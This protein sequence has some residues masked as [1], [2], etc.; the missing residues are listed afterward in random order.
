[1]AIADR[2]EPVSE[3]YFALATAAIGGDVYNQVNYAN[4]FTVIA[5]QNHQLDMASMRHSVE[6]RSPLLDFG[7]ME[8]LMSVPDR[9]KNEHGPK[10]LMRSLVSGLLPEYIVRARKSGPTMPLDDW[11]RDQSVGGTAQRFVVK[12]KDLIADCCSARLASAVGD[13]SLYHGR[14][15]AMRLFAL[16]SLV[17][18]AKHNVE[19]TAVDSPTSF[20]DFAA[21]A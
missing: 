14:A 7:V 12:N 5:N 4:V 15:G 16:V 8:F 11:F 13:E 20:T 19:S 10:S 1:M 17:L 3:D 6:N 21:A 18:W 2:I 9:L